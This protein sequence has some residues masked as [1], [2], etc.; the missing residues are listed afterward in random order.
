MTLFIKFK[1]IMPILL[2]SGFLLILLIKPDIT[3]NSALN[4]LILSGNVIIPSLFPFMV[5]ALLISKSGILNKIPFPKQWAHIKTPLI[6]FTISCIGGYPIGAKIISEEFSNG[7]IGKRDANLL[8]MCSVNAGPSF[9][10]L[11]VGG[12]I[13]GSSAAGIVLFVSHILSSLLIFISLIPCLT[14]D[15]K[16]NRKNS[17]NPT[18]VLVNSVSDSS[19]AM[20]NI[21]GYLVLASTILGIINVSGI[22]KIFKSILSY[23]V[24]ISNAVFNTSNIYLLSAILGFSGLSIIFQ[25]LYIAREIFPSFIK[26]IISRCLHATLSV[27][28]TY[29][30][31]K[32]FPL[33]ISTIANTGG[34]GVTFAHTSVY[35]SLMLIA[36]ALSFVYSLSSKRYCGKINTDIF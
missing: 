4:G 13:L 7:N 31:L 19:A 18:E 32:L 28:V 11:T 24:E 21:C 10:I 36:T 8:L 23:T 5:G 6:I 26:I 3:K 2:T 27:G 12:G 17:E 22:P 9:I 14:R 35:L 15:C 20:L 29:L 1:H 34:S 25:V 30:I 33:S 16:P